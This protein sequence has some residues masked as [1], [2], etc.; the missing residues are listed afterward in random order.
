MAQH[1]RII[2]IRDDLNAADLVQLA[3]DSGL[4]VAQKYEALDTKV[5]YTAVSA[6]VLFADNITTIADLSFNP[7]TN[8]FTKV[9]TDGTTADYDLSAYLDDSNAARIVSGILDVDTGKAKFN[10]DD[11]TEFEVDFSGFLKDLN[12][13]GSIVD[14][15]NTK[16]SLKYDDGDS[17]T[18]VQEISFKEL[19]D[20]TVNYVVIK[21]SSGNGNDIKLTNNNG[22]LETSVA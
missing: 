16:G 3:A 10:R 6:G 8:K 21:D 19:P 5:Q 12:Y 7:Q 22:V 15:I 13:K 11:S 17:T 9:K 18:D 20:V 1:Y 2:T 14:E 4:K